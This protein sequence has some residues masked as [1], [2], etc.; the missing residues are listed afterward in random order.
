MWSLLVVVSTPSLAFSLRIVEAH[1]PVRIQAFRPEL[2]IEGFNE[3]IVGWLS[4]PGEVERHPAAGRP[5]DAPP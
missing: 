5:I 4:W 1:E 3:G 2:A